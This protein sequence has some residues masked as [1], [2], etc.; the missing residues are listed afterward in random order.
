MKDR[1]DKGE[2][3]IQGDEQGP[4]GGR[5]RFEK[6]EQDPGRLTRFTTR[7]VRGLADIEYY[8]KAP[9]GWKEGTVLIWA[10]MRGAVTLAAAQTLP[11]T[12]VPHRNLLIF[13]AF[14]VAAGSL[15]IQG[16]S[17]AWIVKLLKPA[18]P[19]PSVEFEERKKMMDVLRQASETVITERGAENHFDKETRLAVLDAQRNALLDARDDG[20][21]DADVLGSALTVLDADQIAITLRGGP[22]S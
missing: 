13:I 1:L 12:G 5:Q 21:F 8:L 20:T 19:D 18:V 16:G 9:L 4:P 15:L 6:A 22:R 10:G 17:I 3:M 14:A 7:L 2:P 11:E